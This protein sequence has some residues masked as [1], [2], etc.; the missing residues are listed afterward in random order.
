MGE[1]RVPGRGPEQGPDSDGGGQPLPVFELPHGGPAGQATAIADELLANR[2]LQMSLEGHELVLVAE[3]VDAAPRPTRAHQAL[4]GG[5]GMAQLGGDG[6]P[7]VPEFLAMEL[8]ALFGCTHASAAL[9]ISDA[10]NLRH[11]HPR[12]W[13]LLAAGQVRA[14]QARRIAAMAHPLTLE[15]ADELDSVLAPVMPGLGWTRMQRLAEGEIAQIAPDLIEARARAAREHRFVRL[16]REKPGPGVTAVVAHL[17]TADAVHVDAAVDQLARALERHGDGSPLDTR[18]ARA[19]GMLATPALA[20]ALLADLADPVDPLDPVVP[21]DPDGEMPD[22]QQALPISALAEPDDLESLPPDPGPGD[23]P[24]EPDVVPSR[25]W[26]RAR[27]ADL[28]AAF[29]TVDPARLRPVVRLHVHVSAADLEAGCGVARVEGH[30]PV[31]LSQLA[32]F[33]GGCPVRV[34]QVI[35]TRDSQ[36]VD[37]YEIPDR[38]RE[39][40]IQIQP[41]EVAPWG[42]CPHGPA[43]LTTPCPGG[44]AG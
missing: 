24:G 2:S 20:A 9:L 6:T 34:T 39:Q 31:P 8:G 37:S 42:R 35:D 19:M 25:S 11:R 36:T 41:Y 27:T 28:A 17:D 21:D 4:P 26:W 44:P 30:E 14:W 10:L 15:Q 32:E 16:G 23:P 1:E 40:V 3:L 18:R 13:Q 7:R 43:T 38:L 22:W 33:L 12:L 29:R 5:E